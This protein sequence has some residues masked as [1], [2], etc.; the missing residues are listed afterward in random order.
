MTSTPAQKRTVW[1]ARCG[2]SQ[3]WRP[4]AQRFP[5]GGTT[6]SNSTGPPLEDPAPA[7]A[8]IAR[9]AV[10]GRLRRREP[11][12]GWPGSQSPSSSRSSAGAG[13]KRSAGV[14]GARSLERLMRPVGVVVA[15]PVVD[16][17][18][19]RQ[20]RRRTGGRRRATRAATSDGSARSCPVVVGER[21]AVSR[22]VIPLRRQI[23]SN[24]T[25]PP[26][27]KRSVNCL[28]LSVSTSSGAP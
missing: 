1:P 19:R 9:S 25:S 11:R 2:P 13:V 23:L 12:R 3:N 27:P 22:C 24:S 16:R 18:L 17:G 8:S 28:P 15:H 6:R 14:T 10:G 4:I 26:R 20:E 5:E 7:P 21:G